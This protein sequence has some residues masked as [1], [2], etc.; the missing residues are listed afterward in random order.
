MAKNTP[1][2]AN[3]II[4]RTL[5]TILDRE[6]TEKE[7]TDIWTYFDSRC[8]YCDRQLD[9]KKREGDMDHLEANRCNHISN[10][11]LSCSPCNAHEKRE[12]PWV[13]FLRQQSSD[14]SIFQA[15]KT[16][17]DQWVAKHQI[18]GN[19][20]KQHNLQL[21]QE[22]ELVTQTLNEAVARLR[23]LRAHADT[24]D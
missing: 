10:R 13:K 11:V 16:R 19:I 15:R 14:D 7:K 18:A 17:I 24:N 9:R 22:M 5:K 4:R 8:C 21:E 6:L 12:Y 23:N 3:N 1:S 2:Y 20:S